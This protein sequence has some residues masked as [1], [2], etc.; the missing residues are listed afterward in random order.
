MSWKIHAVQFHVHFPGIKVDIK[1]M[2]KW[3]KETKQIRPRDY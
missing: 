3:E 1:S 2:G